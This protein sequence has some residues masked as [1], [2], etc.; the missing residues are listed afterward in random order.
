M[1]DFFMGSNEQALRTVYCWMPLVGEPAGTWKLF[2]K[3]LI[4]I[5]FKFYVLKWPVETLVFRWL[6]VL[7]QPLLSEA[8]VLFRSAAL[9]LLM[10]LP[11][12]DFILVPS[13]LP[14]L[15]GSIRLPRSCLRCPLIAGLPR[16][17]GL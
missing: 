6:A 13:N 9:R 1:I 11:C 4:S 14:V 17:L 5:F 2:L 16:V 10:W 12:K 7:L 8:L 3:R 15:G